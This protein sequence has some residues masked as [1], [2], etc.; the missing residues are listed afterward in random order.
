MPTALITG[1]TSGIG[2]AFARRL[3][4]DRHDLVLVARDKERLDSAAADARDAGVVV[5]VLPTDL[6]LP[7]DRDHVAARLADP[8]VAPIDLLVNNAGL[9]TPG[10]L[11]RRNARRPAAPARRQRHRGAGADPRCA[12]RHA[13]PRPRRGRER[14]EHRGTAARPRPRL[15]RRQGVGRR[16][17]PRASPLSLRGHRRAR[18]GAVSRV[19]PHRVPR[20]CRASTSARVVG[21]SG[22]TPTRVVDDC[23]ADLER[24]RVLSVPSRQYQAIVALADLLPR[25]VVR[26]RLGRGRSVEPS[27]HGA[28]RDRRRQRARGARPA[29]PRARAW[30]T[31]GS[32][33]RRAPRPTT[34]STCAASPCTTG[35][36][37]WSGA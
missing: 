10:S 29:G 18:D 25:S 14:R 7:T 13:R 16:P 21:R 26:R 22:S 35:P 34:T 23:L 33:S 4:R 11:L 30:C 28:D 1:A 3:T 31:G 37:R 32:P 15:R 6:S 17:S 5:E 19:R 8:D 36:P 20:A 2:A 27:R 12:A 9:T 24:G